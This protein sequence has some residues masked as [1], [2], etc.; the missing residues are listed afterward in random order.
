MSEHLGKY[1]KM[2]FSVRSCVSFVDVISFLDRYTEKKSSI[3]KIRVERALKRYIQRNKDVTLLKIGQYNMY[4]R[5]DATRFDKLE[6]LVRLTDFVCNE[7]KNDVLSSLKIL[8]E[9]IRQKSFC[10]I[11]KKYFK[12]KKELREKKS[13][14]SSES[15]VTAL[16]YLE[17][18][19]LLYLKAIEE[20]L[21]FYYPNLPQ[22]KIFSQYLK[23]F[24]INIAKKKSKNIIN[25]LEFD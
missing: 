22:D 14:K 8:I 5:N 18:N 9:D 19:K 12:D 11:L 23:T 16:N 13:I 4:A 15:F 2:L 25:S 17:Q 24:T 1:L 6:C 21:F 3:D 10:F 20:N 7:N